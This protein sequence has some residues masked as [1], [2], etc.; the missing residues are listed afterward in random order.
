MPRRTRQA[1]ALARYEVQAHP[2][3]AYPRHRG[4][5]PALARRCGSKGSLARHAHARAHHASSAV[6]CVNARAGT[7]P[8]GAHAAKK[9]LSHGGQAQREQQ[10]ASR[11][12]GHAAIALTR[13]DGTRRLINIVGGREAAGGREMV[14]FWEAPHD[15]LYGCK[16]KGG[17]FARS[18]CIVRVPTWDARG[19]EAIEL[20]LSAMLASHRASR[21]RWHNCAFLITLCAWLG[22][23]EW[24]LSPSGML[25]CRVELATS[26][27]TT[28]TP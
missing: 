23:A 8:H 16:G 2:A 19:I 11:L 4:V 5:G 22:P 1:N 27:P 3:A 20:Y 7:Q 6:R 18:M 24:R 25:P 26:L 21:A 15:Y 17:V 10:P 13:P 12:V 14:E 9:P 28:P